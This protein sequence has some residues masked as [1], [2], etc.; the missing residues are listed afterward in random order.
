[1]H[2][3]HRLLWLVLL[4]ALAACGGA[5]A[6]PTTN[7]PVT[8]TSAAQVARV[9]EVAARASATV[10]VQAATSTAGA[11]PTAP[12]AP[13]ATPTTRPTAATSPTAA[14]RATPTRAPSVAPALGTPGT[15]QPVVLSPLSDGAA[16]ADPDGRF[17][18]TVPH[19]W[20]KN[21]TPRS[22]RPDTA[23]RFTG[24]ARPGNSP[25]GDVAIVLEDV[26]SRPALTPE[27]HAQDQVAQ[28]RASVP[29]YRFISLEPV[30][31]DQRPAY[32]HAFQGI[33]RGNLRY[34]EEFY[35]LEA[36]TAHILTFVSLPEERQDTAPTFAAIAGSYRIGDRPPVAPAPAWPWI[37]VVPDEG[38]QHYR[39]GTPLSYQHY[40]PSSGPHY[41][42]PQPAGVYQAEVP[43][44]RWMHSLEH[45]YVVALVRCPDGCPELYQQLGA[46]YQQA[47][48]GPLGSV[49]LIVTPYSGDFSDPT[50]ETPLTLLAW[51]RELMLPRFDPDAVRA[52]YT[53]Y[54]DQG[55]EA[56]P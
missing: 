38:A 56:V 49:K 44:G 16:Y 17:S 12:P 30:I 35:L 20:A 15:G 8:Q 45:G 31:I 39:E 5:A 3:L 10:D 41:P 6:T 29:E 22:S 4:L 19:G 48:K 2:R 52:F 7:V 9:T 51:N 55:P 37:E 27:G 47:P 34:Q 36:P 13:T 54:V 23:V 43:V 14:S 50:K 42:S 32:R 46:F 28:L 25:V 53:A 33:L 21:N 26:S 24:P 11:Q 18:F 40:P 1:V